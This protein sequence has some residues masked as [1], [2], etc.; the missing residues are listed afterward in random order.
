MNQELS[1]G[2][3]MVSSI[4]LSNI[5]NKIY[6]FTK[7]LF[8][9][10]FGLIGI[11]F[12]IPIALIIK[13]IYMCSKDFSPIFFKQTRIGK[14]GK[15]FKL[16]KFR[17]MVPNADEVLKKMLKKDKGLAKEYRKYRKL[18]KDPRI[19]KTGRFLRKSSLDELPQL[20]NVLKGEM[21]LIG[22]RPY[23]P[24]EKKAM[25]KFYNTIIITKPGVTGYWQV[26]GRSDLTFKRRLKLE[27]YYSEN[28]GFLLDAKIFFKTF[29]VVFKW[30]VKRSK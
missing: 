20:I 30:V 12:L 21:S 16:Y 14:N 18:L 3:R 27:K 19:T 17:T 9:I 28:C 1:V 24:R 4:S 8:D 23:L 7:R 29:K 15:E 26:S 5:K 25:G 11:I 22:N 2:V 13:I 10:V 6:L